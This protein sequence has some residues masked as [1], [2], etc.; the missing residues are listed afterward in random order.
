VANHVFLALVATAMVVT[1]PFAVWI[2]RALLLSPNFSATTRARRVEVYEQGVVLLGRDGPDAVFRFDSLALRSSIVVKRVYG[3]Q[4]NARHVHTLTDA[5]GRTR[6]LTE[7]YQ[8]IDALA[9]QLQEGVARAQLA[10]VLAAVRSGQEV[11]FGPIAVRP[12]GIATPRGLLAWDA[13]HRMDIVNG[14][15][16]IRAHGKRLLFASV[17]ASAVL[18]RQCMLAAIGRLRP[19]RR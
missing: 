4:L 18:N 9:Q 1:I 17:K 3:I 6:V 13:L 10:G 5:S 2:V 14:V 11:S 15:I 8:G 16:Q 7:L 12:D 19:P